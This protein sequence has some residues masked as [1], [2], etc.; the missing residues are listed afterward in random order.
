MAE[1]QNRPFVGSESP[2]ATVELVAISQSQ[3]I[4]GGGRMVERKHVEVRDP[5]ALSPDVG[6]TD[7]R[8]ESV[9]PGV[10]A[11]RIAEVP[12]IT[13]G[14][15]QRVLQG[16]L[17][18]IDIPEDPVRDREEAITARANQVDE[19]RLIT[20]LCRF[21]EVAIH[22]LLPAWTSIGDA[23]HL[24]WWILTQR[25]WKIEPA[26]LDESS[27]S[28]LIGTKGPTSP[29]CSPAPSRTARRSA[30]R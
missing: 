17:G 9:N 16:I 19:C 5:S 29:R 3:K 2:K 18:P 7:I 23:V 15:H 12:Q 28:G 4:V 24:Y 8:E 10:E 14:D 27:G 21:D 25:R 30:S 20:V 1:H 6:N 13:P 26:I 22:R 11:V